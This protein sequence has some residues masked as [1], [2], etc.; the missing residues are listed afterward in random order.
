MGRHTHPDDVED[1]LGAPPIPEPRPRTSAVADLHLV[2]HNPRLLAGCAAAVAVPFA[3][4]FIVIVS[5]HELHRW[6]LILAGGLAG[7]V[8]DRAYARAV[9]AQPGTVQPTTTVA[10]GKT[11][12]LN[13]QPAKLEPTPESAPL[14]SSSISARAA[15]GA[16][17]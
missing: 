7:A 17:P 2:V 15:E 1:E 4:Y 12:P 6:A 16:H 3:V 8:L 9:P 13:V 14:E 5:S 10:P 11:A